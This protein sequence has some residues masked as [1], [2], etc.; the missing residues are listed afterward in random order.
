MRILQVAHSFPPHNIA[1]TEVY[2]YNLSRALNKSHKVSIFYRINDPNKSEFEIMHNEYKGLDIYAVNNTFRSCDSFKM[3]YD[4]DIINNKFAGLLSEIKP[5]IVH[6]QHLLFLSMGIIEE[7]K[8]QGIPIV[9]TLNDYWLLCHQGQLLKDNLETCNTYD[10]YDCAKCLKFLLSMKKGVMGIY[11]FLKG[12]LPVFL[13]QFIKN[14][15]FGY[16]RISVNKK[17]EIN[18]INLRVRRSKEI[19]SMVDM[20]LSPSVFL[21]RKFVEF[22]IPENKIILSGYGINAK[23][24]K[25][26]KIV[27]SDRIRFGFIGTLLPAKGVHILISAFNKIQKSNA[28]LKIYGRNATYKGFEYYLKYIKELVKNK[29]IHFM[30][31]YDNENIAKIFSGIDVL[32]IPSIWY[33]NSPLV[34]REAFLAKIPVITSKIGGIPE[35]VDD[36]VNGVLFNPEDVNDLKEKIEYIINNPEIIKKF[37]DNMPEIKSIEKNAKELEEMYTKLVMRSK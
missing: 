32:V 34:I 37:K 5:D 2:T 22:G 12:R 17:E 9:F 20:F 35:L 33:E 24:L 21:R 25:E 13:L 15:Y 30:G 29:N 19:C 10:I 31:G 11:H 1:G 7:I 8:K 26:L 23:F 18:Q 3:T 14:I 16:S 27:K 4:N 28:E 36:G 6:I